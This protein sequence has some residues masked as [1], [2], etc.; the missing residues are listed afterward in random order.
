MN[1]PEANKDGYFDWT[2]DMSVGIEIIDDDHKSFFELVKTF[3]GWGRGTAS[4]LVIESALLML[5]EYVGGHFLREEK[6]MQKCAYPKLV[7]HTQKHSYFRTRVQTISALYSRGTKSAI[8][9]LPVMVVEWLKQH[10][11]G[12]DVQFKHWIRPLDVDSRPLGFLAM[13]ASEIN[14]DGRMDLLLP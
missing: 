6:A 7:A 14:K 5:E 13:E 3:S 4:D 1:E 12:E 9:D 11:L 8:D 10:I 2:E